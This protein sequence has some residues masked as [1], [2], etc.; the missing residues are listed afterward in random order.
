MTHKM[1]LLM[2]LSL[3]LFVYAIKIDDSAFKILA[4]FG[5]ATAWHYRKEE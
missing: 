1:K 4:G 5:I 2:C 3:I